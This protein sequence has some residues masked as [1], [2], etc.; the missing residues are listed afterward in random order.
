M[1]RGDGAIFKR[2]YFRMQA[3]AVLLFALRCARLDTLCSVDETPQFVSHIDPPV[4][5]PQ[6]ISP[7]GKLTS[8][9]RFKSNM[10]SYQLPKTR[11]ARKSIGVTV[12]S[13]YWLTRSWR[14]AGHK[15]RQSRSEAVW[16]VY[17]PPFAQESQHESGH[18][19]RQLQLLPLAPEPPWVWSIQGF[20]RA[21]PRMTTC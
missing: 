14:A 5:G 10:C 13:G 19:A 17:R 20:R 2:G 21:R 6:P 1:D 7:T 12:G 8:R 9:Q 4:N 15:F 3:G 16:D 11:N 18:L